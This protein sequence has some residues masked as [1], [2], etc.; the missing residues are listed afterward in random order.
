MQDL[1]IGDAEATP[2]LR[3][4]V[5]EDPGHREAGHMLALVLERSGQKSDL[6]ELLRRQIEAAKDRSDAEAVASLALRL[7]LLVRETDREGARGLFYIGLDWV[8]NNRELLDALIQLLDTEADAGE[9][10]DV[11][12]RRLALEQG[13]GAEEMAASLSAV[14]MGFGDREGAC[15][16]LEM[17]LQAHP[18]SVELRARLESM[19]I[20]EAV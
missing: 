16:A 17:G 1:R 18:T 14:R 10:A 8:A 13:P 12:E 3:E 20:S 4:I 15:R 19:S 2:L 7:G 11:L 5:E 9:R 6:V